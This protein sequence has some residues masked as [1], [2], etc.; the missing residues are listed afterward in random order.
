MKGE[1]NGQTDLFE[2]RSTAATLLPELRAKLGIL[3]QLLLAEAAG[4]I[5][6][7]GKLDVLSV[8]AGDEQ[9]HG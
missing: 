2:Q 7:E 6:A 4:L 1:Q 8:E 3:L 9:D 5:Q